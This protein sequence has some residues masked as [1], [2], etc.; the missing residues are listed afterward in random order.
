MRSSNYTLYGDLSARVMT[1]LRTFTPNLEVYSIDEAFLSFA[2]FDNRLDA[3]A[4]DLRATVLDGP[5]SRSRSASAPPKRWPRSPTDRQK[6]AG[7]GRVCNLM[8]TDDQVAAL[9]ALTPTD[10]WGIAGRMVKRLEHLGID[11]PLKLR[12]ANPSHVRNHLGVVMERMALELRGIPCH[13]LVE[14]NPDNKSILASRSFGRAVTTRHELPEA[15]SSHTER[16]VE[17]LRCQKLCASVLRVFVMTN[18]FN[19]Q[20]M[21]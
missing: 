7:Q 9:S 10:L 8:H 14:T 15:V 3:H 11:T 18:P 16:A 5:A 1:V 2:G 13:S 4:K 12:N 17:K 21:Q 20:E 6:T 19:P